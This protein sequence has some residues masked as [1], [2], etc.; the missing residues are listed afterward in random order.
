MQRCENLVLALDIEARGFNLDDNDVGSDS[1]IS[2]GLGLR[3][4][5][6]SA[7]RLYTVFLDVSNFVCARGSKKPVFRAWNS[8]GDRKV[9]VK[10]KVL[11]E[12]EVR[13]Q[14]GN[15]I[16]KS[17]KPMFLLP[18]LMNIISLQ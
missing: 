7:P 17:G 6:P 9:K 1:L 5:G 15:W 3:Q 8:F 10:M 18:V 2:S 4:V 14:L 13:Y 16:R 12:E 11:E